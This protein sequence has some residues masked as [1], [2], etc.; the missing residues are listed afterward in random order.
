MRAGARAAI[1]ITGLAPHESLRTLITI[2]KMEIVKIIQKNII[3][4][5]W[6]FEYCE[7]DGISRFLGRHRVKAGFQI[8]KWQGWPKGRDCLVW[9]HNRRR[10]RIW[11]GIAMIRRCFHCYIEFENEIDVLDLCDLCEGSSWMAVIK[12]RGAAPWKRDP[13]LPEGTLD[14]MEMKKARMTLIAR[15]KENQQNLQMRKIWEKAHQ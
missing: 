8:F 11:P 2:T 6:Q 13:P 7:R 14:N 9:F 15:K 3:E 5:W 1:T 10:L 4:Q 12:I